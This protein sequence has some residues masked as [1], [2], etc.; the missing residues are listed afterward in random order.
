MSASLKVLPLLLCLFMTACPSILVTD[1][2]VTAEKVYADIESLEGA[3]FLDLTDT[4]ARGFE[5][6]CLTQDACYLSSLS[7][8]IVKVTGQALSGTAEVYAAKVANIA[9]GIDMSTDGRLFAALSFAPFDEWKT[10]GGA[11]YLLDADLKIAPVRLTGDYPAIN[12]LACSGSS[13]YFFTASNFSFLKPFGTVYRGSTADYGAEQAARGPWI[14]NGIAVHHDSIYFS[15]TLG[16]ILRLHN[17]DTSWTYRKSGMTEAVDDFCI[18]AD[19]CFWMTDPGGAAVKRFDPAKKTLSRFYI[20]G[21]GQTSACAIREED[22]TQVLYLTELKQSRS[23]SSG[24]YDG[25]GAAVIPV[26]SLLR[27]LTKEN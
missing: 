15:D 22:G 6:I 13:D 10:K 11:V 20:T 16:G 27:N 2:S 26:D 8:H 3:V 9:L 25:R 23:R 24:S 19:G 5:N 4:G 18:D 17:G 1:S 21:I 7:G 12:G 14:A